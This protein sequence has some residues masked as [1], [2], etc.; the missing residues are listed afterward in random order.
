MNSVRVDAVLTIFPE[1]S[2]HH[3]DPLDELKSEMQHPTFN[4]RF[5]LP[6]NQRSGACHRDIGTCRAVY[7]D[8]L[9]P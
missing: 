1:N 6:H 5:I 7:L 9:D 4:V 3:F 8:D 2:H